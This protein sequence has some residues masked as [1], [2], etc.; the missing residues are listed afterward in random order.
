MSTTFDI[1]EINANI[2]LGKTAT[3]ERPYADDPVRRYADPADL[4]RHQR[5]WDQAKA[6]DDDNRRRRDERI[7]AVEATR[8][9]EIEQRRTAA[10]DR[11]EADVRRDFLARPG[12]DE[13]DWQRL[14]DRLIDD[15]L[16]ATPSPVAQARA[17]LLKSGAFPSI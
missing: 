6:W 2:Y 16:L 10:R 12:V 5:M 17:A 3:T 15:V 7:A 14:K 11:M 4:A 9:A 8:L 13:S 1:A